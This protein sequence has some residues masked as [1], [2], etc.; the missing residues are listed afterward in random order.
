VILIELPRYSDNREHSTLF[1]T[2]PNVFNA[3]RICVLC[4]IDLTNEIM[5]WLQ[6]KTSLV[7]IEFFDVFIKSDQI[8]PTIEQVESLALG[9]YRFLD[10]QSYPTLFALPRFFPSAA[11]TKLDLSCGDRTRFPAV[12]ALLTTMNPTLRTLRLHSILTPD[13]SRTKPIDDLLPRFTS[14]QELDL[15]SAFT[16]HDTHKHLLSLINLVNLTIALDYV[17]ADIKQLFRGPKRLR[18]LRRVELEFVPIPYGE[19]FD[20]NSAAMEISQDQRGGG[21]NGFALLDN[22]LSFTT[23]NGWDLPF[24]AE[25]AY[26]DGMELADSIVEVAKEAEIK[27]C[28]YNDRIRCFFLRKIVEYYNQGIGRLYFYNDSKIL[29]DARRVASKH[30]V[31]LPMLEINPEEALVQEDVEWFKV[32]MHEIE[33][34]ELDWCSAWNLRYTEGRGH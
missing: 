27:I 16:S 14:L 34:D 24:G 13:D 21:W 18:Y 23:M 6:R 9:A 20:F 4:G 26:E 29:E 30:E 32:E 10:L 17:H 19:A 3:L 5:Q 15:S 22:C 1:T 25:E 31:E 8:Y 12:R 11:I 7:H 33:A 2:L 28:D